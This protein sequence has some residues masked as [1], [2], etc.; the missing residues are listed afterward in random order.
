MK[1]LLNMEEEL[2]LQFQI[3]QFRSLALFL[4]TLVMTAVFSVILYKDTSLEDFIW[5]TAAMLS[6]PSHGLY[7]LFA[8]LLALMAIWVIWGLCCIMVL[9]ISRYLKS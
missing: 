8:A 6:R 2:F 3:L 5:M 7:N 1:K 9:S 4:L